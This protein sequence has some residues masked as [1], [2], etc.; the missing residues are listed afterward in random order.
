MPFGYLEFSRA[1]GRK[2]CPQM[3]ARGG[4]GGSGPG[5]GL[6]SGSGSPPAAVGPVGWPTAAVVGSNRCNGS[7]RTV[8]TI[9]WLRTRWPLPERY[10]APNS[11]LK[12]KKQNLS[13]SLS[14][15]RTGSEVLLHSELGSEVLK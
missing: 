5:P 1:I 7:D 11:Q 4:G 15:F 14:S 3:R 12:Q 9:R 10:C 13:L 8:A 6:G 2:P